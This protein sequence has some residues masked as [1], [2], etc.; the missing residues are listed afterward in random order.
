[1]S[2][3]CRPAEAWAATLAEVGDA[4]FTELDPTDSWLRTAGLSPAPL[5]LG[6]I[7]YRVA[8]K[9]AIAQGFRRAFPFE[10]CGGDELSVSTTNR[11][12]LRRIPPKHVER[13]GP[14]I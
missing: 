6:V 9:M 7:N 11:D 5:E 4:G 10:H 1:M 8:I 2:C 13:A 14:L 12:Y 3:C